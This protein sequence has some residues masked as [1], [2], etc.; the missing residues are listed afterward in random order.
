MTACRERFG[1]GDRA[2]TRRVCGHGQACVSAGGTHLLRRPKC[3]VLRRDAE[4]SAGLMSCHCF[5]RR[6][7]H[8]PSTGRTRSARSTSRSALLQSRSARRGPLRLRPPPASRLAPAQARSSVQ[9]GTELPPAMVQP[10]PRGAGGAA[11]RDREGALHA[12]SGRTH[13]LSR[14][15][16]SVGGGTGIEIHAGCRP[17][18]R[19]CPVPLLLGHR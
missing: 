6:A 2:S 11:R 8:Q 17:W 19:S 13:R 9:A 4:A 5:A 10:V 3:P 14:R 12:G 1:F 18:L 15:P 16:T 7:D